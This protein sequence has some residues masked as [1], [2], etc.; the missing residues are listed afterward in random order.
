MQQQALVLPS[1]RGGSSA[2]ARG[3]AD[4]PD[5]DQHHCYHHAPKV[6]PEP[7]TA[8]VELLT[9]GVGTPETC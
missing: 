9:M 1:E 6:K 8:L 3:R 5:H 7:A 4:R 2:L